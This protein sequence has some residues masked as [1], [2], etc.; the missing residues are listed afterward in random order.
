MLILELI[1]SFSQ[2]IK[3]IETIAFQVDILGDKPHIISKTDLDKTEE[4]K[5]KSKLHQKELSKSSSSISQVSSDTQALKHFPKIRNL[6]EK[7]KPKTNIVFVKTVKTASS[8]LS[9]ILSRYAMKN[10]LNIHGCEMTLYPALRSYENWLRK[11]LKLNHTQL[12]DSNI[13]SEHIWY[14]RKILSDIIP[15]DTIYVTQLRDPLAQL[16]SWLNFNEQFNVTDP[17]EVYKNL[18]RKMKY[19]LWNSWRQL[20]IPVKFTAKQFQSHLHQLDKEFDLVTITEQ[21]DLSLL[22]LRRKLCWDISDMIYIPLKKA[23]YILNKNINSS[24]ITN[25][26]ALNRRYR[27]LNPNAYSLYNH[28]NETLSSLVVR[29]GQDLKEEL[30]YF[31]ELNNN[32]SKYC[33]KYI[34]HII[35]KSSN[36]LNFANSSEVLDIPVSRWGTAHTVDPVECA[37]MKLFKETF[38]DISLMKKL[39]LNSVNM[40]RKTKHIT[41]WLWTLSQPGHPKYGIPLPVLKHAH[42]YDIMHGN[43]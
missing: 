38:Q 9:N 22:L 11:I 42:A 15:N 29:A 34:K 20:R 24:H 2:A 7:C 41:N 10:N 14:K 36:F 3:V 31:Q 28:F 17:V 5:Q 33:S 13:I 16:V 1:N 6:Q 23:T 32:V 40:T 21:F 25:K 39:D 26:Q 37:M 43:I 27:T 18:R 4:M 35:H 30:V 19:D 8:T 12:G